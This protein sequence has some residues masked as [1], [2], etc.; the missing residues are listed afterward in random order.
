MER[1]ILFGDALL[2]ASMGP[3]LFSRGNPA[4][5][6]RCRDKKPA[7]MGPRLFSRGNIVSWEESMYR[8]GTASMGPRLFSR[9]NSVLRL[10][11]KIFE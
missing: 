2:L 9:G 11:H 4:D 1:E 7:S 8:D 5:D 3:R 10:S 6:T